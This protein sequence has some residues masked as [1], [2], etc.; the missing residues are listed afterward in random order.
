MM[1]LGFASQELQYQL[2]EQLGAFTFS[3][4][5]DLSKN[6]NSSTEFVFTSTGRSS[7]FNGVDKWG[8]T[9]LINIDF[10]DIENNDISGIYK[11]CL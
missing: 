3:R 10:I 6:P 4:P 11:Y 1:S 7:L 2:A 9:Y 5:E 8:T